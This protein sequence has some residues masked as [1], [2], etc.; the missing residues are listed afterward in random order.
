MLAILKFFVII[1]CVVLIFSA[2]CGVVVFISDIKRF[3]LDT[4]MSL[5]RQKLIERYVDQQELEKGG[6]NNVV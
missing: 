3:K 2:L 4:Q 5:P 1:L 6:D